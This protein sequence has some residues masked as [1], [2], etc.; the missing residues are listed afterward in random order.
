[1]KKIFYQILILKEIAF[2][3]II[4]QLNDSA[5]LGALLRVSYAFNVKTIITLDRSVPKENS[6]IASI[7]SG[8]LDKINIFKVKKYN[9]YY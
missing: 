2:I 6:Y 9:K 7:A 5:K 3:L 4:D 1:M 8:A